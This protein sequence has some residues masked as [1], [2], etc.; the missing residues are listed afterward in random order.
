MVIRIKQPDSRHPALSSGGNRQLFPSINIA[1]WIPAPLLICQGTALIQRDMFFR[2]TGI[3][4]LPSN[5]HAVLAAV[6]PLEPLTHGY[7][8]E[9]LYAEWPSAEDKSAAALI[10]RFAASC[11]WAVN[12][13]R[14]MPIQSRANR[15]NA[16]N[17]PRRS[18]NRRATCQY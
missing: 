12:Q 1:S 7:T 8:G 14:Q 15:E 6:R 10:S 4:A 16:W 18:S 11:M 3:S 5:R 2:A 17:Y 13:L 9:R